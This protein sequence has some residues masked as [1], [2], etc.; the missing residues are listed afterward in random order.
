MCI[1]GSPDY[2]NVDHVKLDIAIEIF[3]IVVGAN[4]DM[5]KTHEIYR[6]SGYC[7]NYQA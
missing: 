7:F 6:E 3:M 5:R 2:L 4:A 1:N